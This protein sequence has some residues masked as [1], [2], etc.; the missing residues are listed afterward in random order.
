MLEAPARLC[1]T[2][3]LRVGRITGAG[4]GHCNLTD[5]KSETLT[6]PGLCGGGNDGGGCAPTWQRYGYGSR[7][8]QAY[9]SYVSFVSYAALRGPGRESTTTISNMSREVTDQ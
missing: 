2:Y 4:R 7:P 5:V 8:D 9:V 6:M 3:A 1:V